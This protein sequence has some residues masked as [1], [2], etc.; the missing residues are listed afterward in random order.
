MQMK[1]DAG[2][3][4]ILFTR[5]HL[6][7]LRNTCEQVVSAGEVDAVH[8]FRVSSRRLNEPLAVMSRWLGRKKVKAVRRNLNALRKT[9]R[10]V[11]DLDVL[12]MSL[13]D[14]RTVPRMDSEHARE[15]ADVLARRRAVQFATAREALRDLNPTCVIQS[16]KTL[17]KQFQ[18][19][20]AELSPQRVRRRARKAW[21]RRA[22]ALLQRTPLHDAATDLHDARIRLKK[23]R[24][25]T[26]LMYRLL[27]R[28]R[29]GL[30]VAMT[31]M[32]DVLGAWCDHVYAAAM[33]AEI[34]SCGQA[35]AMRTAWCG[36]VLKHA[37][38]RARLAESDRRE[39]LSAWP[40]LQS[41]IEAALAGRRPSPS[42]DGQVARPESVRSEPVRSEPSLAQR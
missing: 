18:E 19:R 1:N 2:E 41:A 24:Y 35:L 26:E 30:L 20:A 23:L 11:R 15:L 39:A 31:G 27:D 14:A 29:D 17:S 4:L 40:A 6:D 38:H 37:A 32:Q 25:S 28:Q 33:F 21:R 16:V 8:D 3:R 22:V 42:G 10:D 12:Q 13:A 34:G 5:K 7:R 9:L 36:A